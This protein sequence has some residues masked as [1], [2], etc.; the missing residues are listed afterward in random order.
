MRAL[1]P[2]PT[3]WPSRPWSVYRTRALCNREH[4][5]ADFKAWEKWFRRRWPWSLKQMDIYQRIDRYAADC[6]QAEFSEV[7]K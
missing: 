5:Y 6:K 4:D 1:H 2:K 7:A 3:D